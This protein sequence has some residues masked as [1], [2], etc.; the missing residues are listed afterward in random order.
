MAVCRQLGFPRQT[1]VCLGK[2]FTSQDAGATDTPGLLLLAGSARRL[3]APAG[4]P[5]FRAAL[6]TVAP[7]EGRRK[8]AALGEQAQDL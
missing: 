4:S 7:Q 8:R 2:R 3:A 5:Q 1:A 6:S